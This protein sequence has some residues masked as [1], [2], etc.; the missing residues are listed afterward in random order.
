MSA[1]MPPRLFF[2]V[3]TKSHL[4][5]ARLLYERL[6]MFEGGTEFLAFLIDGE[7][8]FVDFAKEA[9]PVVRAE[10]FI[11]A[12][13]LRWM[14]FWYTANEFCNAAKAFAHQYVLENRMEEHWFY[15]DSDLYPVASLAPALEALEDHDLLI[16]PHCLEPIVSSG[17]MIAET[18]LLEM[19]VFNGGFLGL[20]RGSE[21]KQF[22]DWFAS[23]LY[24][25]CLDDRP[26][27]FVDQKWLNLAPCLVEKTRI[28]RHPGANVAYW[29]LHERPF[30]GAPSDWTVLGQ[31]LLFVHFSAFQP[32]NPEGITAYNRTGQ[33]A[34]PVWNELARAYAD[35]LRR[36][37]W[38]VARNW[39]YS[40]ARYPS[41]RLIPRGH[42][43]ACNRLY[44]A[45]TA[46]DA[47]PFAL[48][49]KWA[50]A[51]REARLA[52]WR[53]RVSGLFTRRPSGPA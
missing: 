24:A 16:T 1:A 26:Q 46:C 52:W 2:T 53:E 30:S 8:G 25:G 9:F 33:K 29:N 31:P 43:L 6:C 14:R 23:V 35:D 39:P 50:T 20:R 40:Y 37:G 47:D 18:G 10:E 19:G 27:F 41:G 12:E 15:L 13:K 34:P 21:A 17:A 5:Y 38:E 48:E 28:W 22:V 42:R 36:H 4:P 32:E 44:R 7:D 49:S 3:V 45:G 11:A 51:V